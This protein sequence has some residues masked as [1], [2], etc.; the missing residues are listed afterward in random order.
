MT[1]F[2]DLIDKCV[3]LRCCNRNFKGNVRENLLNHGFIYMKLKLYHLGGNKRNILVDANN[4]QIQNGN[5]KEKKAQDKM[6]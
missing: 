1:D 3:N 6:K 2:Q 5:R 4:M